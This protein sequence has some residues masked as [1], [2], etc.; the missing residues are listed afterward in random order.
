MAMQDDEAEII[1]FY[2]RYDDAILKFTESLPDDM[3][4]NSI[5]RLTA[6]SVQ[7]VMCGLQLLAASALTPGLGIPVSVECAIRESCADALRRVGQVCEAA[8]AA[9]NN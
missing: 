8:N 3:R 5:A 4:L 2:D 6:M 7:L 9:S 1:E